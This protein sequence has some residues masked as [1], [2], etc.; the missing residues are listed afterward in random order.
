MDSINVQNV[1][2]TIHHIPNHLQFIHMTNQFLNHH[3]SPQ[4]LHNNIATTNRYEL[5]QPKQRQ[6]SSPTEW[7]HTSNGDAGSSRK[8]LL[9]KEVLVRVR[10]ACGFG[11]PKGITHLYTTRFTFATPT[12]CIREA[13]DIGA[14]N[15]DASGNPTDVFKPESPTHATR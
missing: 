11:D 6:T 5:A 15:I 7:Y 3:R 13:D 14:P 9:V 8:I 2:T 10:H 1:W 12:G 4:S